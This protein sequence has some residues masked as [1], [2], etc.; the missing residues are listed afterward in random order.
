MIAAR[1]AGRAV[2]AAKYDRVGAA[3]RMWDAMA[4]DNVA[5]L[6]AVRLWQGSALGSGF[7]ALRAS[8]VSLC[9]FMF[10]FIVIIISDLR[11]LTCLFALHFYRPRRKA[12]GGTSRARRWRGLAVRFSVNFVVAFVVAWLGLALT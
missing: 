9:L 5:T 12:R 8:A 11:L 6:R 3:V 1:L 10:T 2:A 7:R 4:Q